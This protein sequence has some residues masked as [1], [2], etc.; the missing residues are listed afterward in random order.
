MKNDQKC[1]NK[2]ADRCNGTFW[3]FIQG[4]KMAS[5]L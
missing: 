3:N 5:F 2:M 1:P 4:L